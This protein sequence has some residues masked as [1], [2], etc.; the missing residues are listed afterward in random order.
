MDVEE[1]IVRQSFCANCV[2]DRPT[3]KYGRY[4]LCKECAGKPLHGPK[5]KG[6]STRLRGAQYG[7]AGYKPNQDEVWFWKK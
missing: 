7:G 2:E 1:A 3:T 6:P 5:S 4:W